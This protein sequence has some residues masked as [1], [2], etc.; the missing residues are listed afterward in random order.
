VIRKQIELVR[1]VMQVLRR[2]LN[3]E[4]NVLG[5]CDMEEENGKLYVDVSCN[6]KAIQCYIDLIRK[7]RDIDY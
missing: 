7:Y 4:G 5:R 2:I 3:G 1:V 6:R